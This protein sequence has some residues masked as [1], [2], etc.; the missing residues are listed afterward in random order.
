MGYSVD[1]IP[2]DL[3]HKELLSSRF[4]KLQLD[5]SEYSFAN[6]YLFRKTHAF[7]LI[8]GDEVFLKGKGYDGMSYFMPT[9]DV[10]TR[11]LDF[12]REVL[13]KGDV[14]FPIPEE[15]ISHF[16]ESEFAISTSENDN[17]YVY[18]IEKLRTLPG[19]HLSG[20]RNLIRQFNDNYLAVAFPLSRERQ[21]D[22]LEILE[23]WA[24]LQNEEIGKTDYEACREAISLCETLGLTGEIYYVEEKPIG[25][26]IGEALN[27]HMFVLHFAKADVHYKGI[28]QYMHQ[29]FALKCDDH[30]KFLNWEVD[31]GKEKL[32]QSKNAYEPDHFIKKM[33]VQLR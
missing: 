20:R 33:R 10:R 31:L 32:K 2:L 16:S 14:L 26:I 21:K 22:A 27:K 24:S 12:L 19:R 6:C 18:T 3:S 11:S 29:A 13:K 15:W 8:V 17:D 25:F 4:E 28:Y 23:K 5:I 30:F 1:I 9:F 7:E